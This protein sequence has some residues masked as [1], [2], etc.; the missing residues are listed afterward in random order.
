MTSRLAPFPL[1]NL[2]GRSA[3]VTGGS[4]GIGLEAARALAAAGASVVVTSRTQTRAADA[5]ADVGARPE[6]LDTS[7]RSSVDALAERW[8][9]APVDILVL[10]AGIAPPRR[11][12]DSV[13]GHEL[14]LA[15]NA[16]GHVR[17][18]HALREPLRAASGHVV[19]VGSIAA[20]WADADASDLDLRRRWAR[21]QAYARSKLACVVTALELPVRAG[22]AAVPAHPGWA[23]TPF[24]GPGGAMR[25]VAPL[26]LALP[27]TPASGPRGG[28][29]CAT[30]PG[31]PRSGTRT[32]QPGTD[33]VRAPGAS[34]R[35]GGRAR[36][37]PRPPATT[38]ARVSTPGGRPPTSGREAP[39]PSP[40]RRSPP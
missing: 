25:W 23:T 37:R 4:S 15:T 5:A 18:A 29:P 2:S 11:R 22:I 24:F 8:G 14:T 9:G 40:C 39:A 3:L 35:R 26:A 17:L 10:N 30:A 27:G 6:V 21:G 33:R 36:S 19:T 1:P 16:L 31:C 20:N 12:T 34:P 7:S 32:R 13:D 28:R 38:R